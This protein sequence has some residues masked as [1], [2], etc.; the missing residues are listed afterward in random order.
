MSMDRCV[1]CNRAVDTDTDTDCY[2]GDFGPC[3][4]Q[5]CREDA[6]DAKEP[7]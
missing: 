1:E 3:V 7:T 2:F 5:Q 4:C 6:E